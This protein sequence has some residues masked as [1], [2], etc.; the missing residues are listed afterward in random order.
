MQIAMIGFGR[1]GS[2]MVRRL[3]TA[4]HQCVVF[5][6]SRKPVDELVLERAVGAADLKDV[7]PKLKDASDSLVDDPGSG[8]LTTLS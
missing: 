1:M 7:V 5:N 2:N 8:R 4:G 3:L 6:R